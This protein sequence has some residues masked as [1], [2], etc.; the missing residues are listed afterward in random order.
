MTDRPGVVRRKGVG[1]RVERQL[2]GRHLVFGEGDVHRLAAVGASPGSATAASRNQQREG[3]EHGGPGGR[4]DRRAIAHGG[5]GYWTTRSTWS[6][7]S[8]ISGACWLSTSRA[9]NL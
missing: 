8:G 2:A 9:K 6:A 4:S 1:P 3:E 7:M 5:R